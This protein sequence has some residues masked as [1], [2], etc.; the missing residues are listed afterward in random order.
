MGTVTEIEREALLRRGLRLEYAT[1]C[2]NV[3]ECGVLMVAAVAA[4]SVALAAFAL[5]S[6]IE[7]FASLVVVWHLR[8]EEGTERERRAVRRIGL[9]FLG[10]AAFVAVQTLVTLAA[11][12]EPDES[13]LGIVWLGATVVAMFALARAKYLTGRDVGSRVLLTEAKVTMVDGSLAAAILVGLVL[14][15]AFGW[16]WADL[17][18]GLIIIVYG[19]REGLEALA[20]GRSDVADPGTA[21][22]GPVA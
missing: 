7:I 10:L 17:V 4:R 5:D 20:D 22:G 8:G 1:L 6:V 2:W 13:T 14:N 11:G 9:A 3:V 16:W 21:P 15:A 12:I 18:G 19:I